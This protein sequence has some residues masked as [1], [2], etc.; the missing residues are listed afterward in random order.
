MDKKEYESK[1]KKLKKSG[2]LIYTEKDIRKHI[3]NIE[4]ERNDFIK[5][6]KK[7]NDCDKQPVD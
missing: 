5:N 4:K 1:I 7:I 2:H 6:N 3:Q